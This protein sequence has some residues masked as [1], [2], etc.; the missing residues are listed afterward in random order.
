MQGARCRCRSHCRQSGISVCGV[1]GRGEVELCLGLLVHGLFTL[2]LMLGGQVVSAVVLQGLYVE[3]FGSGVGLAAH[4][5]IPIWSRQA[6]TPADE[7]HFCGPRAKEAPDP[8]GPLLLAEED[9][10]RDDQPKG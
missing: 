6:R 7:S 1:G 4:V 8:L 2:S 9:P 3:H 5:T 10:N